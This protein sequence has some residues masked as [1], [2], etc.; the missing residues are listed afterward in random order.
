MEENKITVNGIDIK[1]KLKKRKYDTQH[2]IVVFSGFG[3]ERLFT[4]DFENALSDCPATILWIKDD[5]YD[6]CSYYLCKNNDYTIESSVITFIENMRREL[7][8]DK[9]QCTLIGFSKGGSASLYFGLKYGFKN[10]IS[11]VPQLKIGAY[12]S[13]TWPEV[14]K[15]M[16]GDC[17]KI[18]LS[19]IDSLLPYVLEND[20][21][22]ERNI[23][24]LTSFS[25]EQYN[26][27]IKDY[28]QYFVRYNNFN[29]FYAQS[30]LIREHNQVTSYHVP[31]ILSICYSL[32]QGAVPRYG[33]CFLEGDKKKG[34][35]S[36]GD[37][38]AILKKIPIKDMIIFPEGISVIKGIPCQ[39]YK[40]ISHSLIFKNHLDTFSFPLANAHRSILTR[41]LYE[42]G[43]VNY[44]KGWFCTTSYQGLDISS[45]PTGKFDVF[46]RVCCGGEDRIIRLKVE[47]HISNRQ[48]I[49]N[50]FLRI[51]SEGDSLVICVK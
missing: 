28:L 29:L 22:F 16:T 51:F 4:Y 19:E 6:C 30:L 15:H 39:E 1:Y 5:F 7:S 33:C 50:E 32:S 34:G 3:L 37:A 25:D 45:L 42:D 12:T 43:Y 38:I 31:L 23:Y 9:E 21:V 41:Q 14:A 48:I 20:K 36:G 26:K 24:L 40:D 49:S 13:V 10:I 18:S 2:L 46:I 17:N 35:H 11:T 8:L 44:D 47:P 27:Q